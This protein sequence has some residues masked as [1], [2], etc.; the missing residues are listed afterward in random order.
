MEDG[1]EKFL[2]EHRER[3]ETGS[4]SSQV[5]QKLQEGLAQHH[6][7]KARIIRI[8]RISYSVAAS[9][10]LAIGLFFVAFNH[11]KTSKDPSLAH[12]SKSHRQ[13]K[14]SAHDNIATRQRLLVAK[15]GKKRKPNGLELTDRE[16]RQSLFYY[17]KL[18]EIR[19]RQISRVQ[20]IDPGLYKKS[21]KGINDLNQEYQHLK[22]KLPAS[23]NQQKLLELMIQNLQLQEQI[24]T[25]QLQLIQS[26]QSPNQSANEK[27]AKNI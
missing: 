19:Q 8:R 17:T 18:I 20:E 14:Q 25:N 16:T 1:F 22:N 5:W 13:L 11:K 21:Q 4:P 9:I 3:F 27:D 15:T 2:L 12:I 6:Q 26:L 23:L 7:R 10:L 24:L